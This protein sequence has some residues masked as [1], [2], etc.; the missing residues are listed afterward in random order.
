MARTWSGVLARLGVPTGDGRI[1]PPGALTSRELP[2]PLLWQEATG[3]GHGGSQVVGRIESM[4]FGDGMVTATGS[5]LDSAPYAVEEQLEAGV[6]GPSVDLDDVDYVM[7]DMERI[8][9]TSGRISGA[10]LVAIPAF[11]DVSIT[12]DPMPI[13]PLTDSEPGMDPDWLYASAAPVRP[14]R[15]WFDRPDLDRLT[16][17][18]V[19]DTGRVFGH[20]AGWSTCHVGLPGCVTAPFSASNYAYFLQGE[21]ATE[22]GST[23]PVGTLTVGGGHADAQLG[24]RPAQAHYDDV[25]TAVAKVMAGEDE[26]G[27]WVAGWVLPDVSSEALDTFRSSP[28]SGDWRRIGGNLELIAVC[29]VNAAGFPVPRARVSFAAQAQR[30]LIASFGVVPR[31]GDLPDSGKQSEALRARW[32]WHSITKGR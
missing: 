28:V 10:T 16:P 20:I 30:T 8:V 5:L 13:E 25:G 22:E 18:T 1:I 26:F 17:L 31:T 19:T 7:D 24:F 27:I 14:P 6:I 3:D 11:A 21:Q 4:A 29:S 9:I 15:E 2:L 23:V 12:L 32:A